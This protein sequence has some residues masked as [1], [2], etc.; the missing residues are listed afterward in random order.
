MG[1]LFSGLDKLGLSLEGMQ[2]FEEEKKETKEK[3]K[4]PEVTEADLLLDRTYKCPVC[5]SSFKSK[6]VKSGKAKLI[7]TEM[8]LRPRFQNVDSLK[9]DAIVC[10]N[11]GYS[12][13]SRFL[14]ILPFRRKN[15][16]ERR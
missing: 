9:Y 6:A 15:W 11:C 2:V 12:A 13:L 7:E 3:E 5:D 4:K 8:D 1:N 16:Y 10:P 14:T